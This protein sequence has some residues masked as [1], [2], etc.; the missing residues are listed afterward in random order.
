MTDFQQWSTGTHPVVRLDDDWNQL[1]D[2]GLENPYSYLIRKNGSYYEAING[3][4]GVITYGGEDNAGGADGTLHHAVVQPAFTATGVAGGGVVFWKNG[5]YTNTVPIIQVTNVH[6]V[7]ESREGVVITNTSATDPIFR[8][9]GATL[10]NLGLHNMS[11][12]TN[13]GAVGTWHSAGTTDLSFTNC[14]FE[15][16]TAIAGFIVFLDTTSGDNDNFRMRHCIFEGL[17]GGDDMFGCGEINNAVVDSNQFLNGD[18]QGM[19][20]AYTD[21]ARFTNNYFYKVGNAIGLESGCY[22]N[23]IQ[24]NMIIWGAGIG[25]SSGTTHPSYWNTVDNNK[26]LY[27]TNGIYSARSYSDIITN[28]TI[29]FT[30][31][32]GIYGSF[33]RGI[34]RGNI[35]KNNNWSNANVVIDGNPYNEGGINVLNDATIPITNNTQVVGNTLYED[36]TNYLHLSGD[37][38]QGHMG[39]IGI[40]TKCDRAIV[41]GNA[42]DGTYGT[43]ND[44][45]EYTTFDG[46]CS[47]MTSVDLSAGAPETLYVP[48]H[49]QRQMSMERITFIYTE[50]S[51]PANVT[52]EVGYERHNAAADP[53]YYIDENTIN[54]QLIWYRQEF[55]SP[56]LDAK[57]ILQGDVITV[58][59]PGGS[60]QAGEVQ[61]AIEW[62]VGY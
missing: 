9:V 55:R 59:N 47:T 19:G 15:A 45:G 25:L 8:K 40:D 58:T 35:L 14:R 18:G 38:R 21:Y 20:V 49:P 42:W 34:I 43:V 4:T 48:F 36:R 10:S 23:L 37:T 52:L 24:G 29:A 32:Q 17:S 33:D 12:K 56:T 26:I 57:T 51:G 13:T 6:G 46:M 22:G 39:G 7:G 2:H 30:Q 11:L 1:L 53:D 60:G 50:A 44:A 41:Q 28:N 5:A 54:N 62:V 16:T 3:S 61:V 27:C 31:T